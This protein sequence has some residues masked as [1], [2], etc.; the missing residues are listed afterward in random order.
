MYKI[1]LI[2]SQFT[3]YPAVLLGS[4]EFTVEA[5]RYSSGVES[6]T[7]RNSRG[8][9]E[10]LPFMGQIIWDLQFDGKSLKMDNMF[11]EPRPATVIVDTYGCFA[12]HSGLLAAGCPAPEDNHPLHGEFPCAPFTDAWLEVDEQ[13]IAISGRREY[14][15]GFGH[16]YEAMPKVVLRALESKIDIDLAVTNLSAYQP[17]PLQYMCHM[18]YAWVD[19]AEMTQSI[20][21]AFKLRAT[22][23]AHVRPTPEWTAFNQEILSGAVDT[24]SLADGSRFDPEIVF[25]ADDLPQHGEQAQ[26]QMDLPEGGNFFVNFATEQFPVATRWLLYNADQKV[27]AFVLPGTSRPEGFLAAQETG[28]LIELAAGERRCFHVETGLEN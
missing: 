17:M 5:R 9:V 8:L 15:Q 10:V 13:S 22:V 20:G 25:F 18:N 26:F 24:S 14:V 1:P 6:V 11:A 4:D 7:I 21:D 27:C 3:D 16:H 28:T 19:G 12:F 2:Q 23:P